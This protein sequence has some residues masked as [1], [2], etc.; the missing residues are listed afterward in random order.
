[1]IRGMSHRADLR[2][3]NRHRGDD[4]TDR[5][6]YALG[7][8]AKLLP[9]L[10]SLL[11]ETGGS[12]PQTGVVDRHPPG[13]SEPWQ[14]DAAAAY[15]TIHAGI[16]DIANGMRTER[17]MARLVWRGHDDATAQVLRQIRNY[18]PVV[19]P[20][21]VTAAATRIEG[22]LASA[23]QIPDI[24]E[25]ERWVPVPRVAGAK[26]PAC[27]YCGTFSLRM[28]RRQGVVRC[29]YPGCA[30][31]DGRPTRASMEPGAATGEGILVFGDSTTMHFREEG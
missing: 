15:W 7:D 3:P 22:W 31:K 10:S 29:F 9:V 28:A 16:R 27:P 26:P 13:S 14:A 8:V 11:P 17:G 19:E 30:D 24:D 12:G 25:V 21:T 20:G 2:T 6:D 5:L 1:M 23:R 18:A 4:D